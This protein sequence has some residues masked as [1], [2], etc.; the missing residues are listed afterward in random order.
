G[1]VGW[2]M[3]VVGALGAAGG[4]CGKFLLERSAAAQFEAC[5]KQSG[6]LASQITQTKEERDT[7]DRQLPRGG[8]PLVTRLQTAEKELARL[9]ELLGV[10]ARRQAAL[11]A[12]AAAEARGRSAEEEGRAAERRWR[13]ALEATGLPNRLS[14]RQVRRYADRR[15][16]MARIEARLERDYQQLGERQR[17]LDTLSRRTEQ[18]LTDVGLETVAGKPTEQLR[19]LK[20][21]L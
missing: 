1:V 18:L 11:E 12:A 14:P 16:T 20:Q 13:Q 3:A 9:E 4:A 10:E 8:G 7:L 19:R 21:L 6:I 15:R 17:E 5:Q 2:A